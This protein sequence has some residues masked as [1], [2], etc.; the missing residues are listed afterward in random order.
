MRESSSFTRWA[1]PAVLVV[2]SGIHAPAQT[3]EI[4]LPYK[5]FQALVERANAPKAAPR[6][7]PVPWAILEAT[8]TLDATNALAATTFTMETFSDGPHAIPLLAATARLETITPGDATILAKDDAFCALVEGR[9]RK[10]VTLTYGCP[11]S[12][13]SAGIQLPIRPA[14]ISTLRLKNLPPQ[15]TARVAGSEPSGGPPE[16]PEWRALPLGSIAVQLHGRESRPSVTLPTIIPTATAETRLVR[17]GALVTTISWN[18]AHT[19]ETTFTTTLPSKSELLSVEVAGRPGTA[20]PQPD[21]SIA[22]RIPP[23]PNG[24]STVRISHTGNTAAF[25]PVRGETTLALPTTPLLVETLS[26]KLQLPVGYEILATEGSVEALPTA[27]PSELA[28][29]AQLVRGTA[30]SVRLFYEKSE[31]KKP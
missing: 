15:S 17:N 29:G 7:P 10:V 18:V 19:A 11:R 27:S 3:G 25:D 14:T 9:Q 31:P 28:L 8:T 13:E 23:A 1:A 20:T 30:P 26:W 12:D 16:A 22:I 2:F 21:G 4:T 24:K 6:V 5:E